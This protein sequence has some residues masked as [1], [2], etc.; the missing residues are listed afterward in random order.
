MA[1]KNPRR[2]SI[3]RKGGP[4]LNRD[5]SLSCHCASNIA[6]KNCT[7]VD[8]CLVITHFVDRLGIILEL[9]VLQSLGVSCSGKMVGVLSVR[10]YES[11]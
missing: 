4:S 6:S 1:I 10:S 2:V 7:A 5:R 9:C 11:M 3:Q 8:S